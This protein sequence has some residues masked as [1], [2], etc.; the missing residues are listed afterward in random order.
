MASSTFTTYYTSP[1]GLLQIAGDATHIHS[2]LFWDEVTT[3]ASSTLPDHLQECLQQLDAY[4]K[5]ERQQ[6]DLPLSPVGTSFQQQVWQQLQ[7]IPFGKTAS[8][9]EVARVVSGEKAIRA[10]GGANGR[11][12]ISI[13]VPCHRVIGSDGSLTGYAGGLWRKEWLLQHEGILKPKQQL[14]LF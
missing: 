1:L 11:N 6:F 13:V 7:T 9:L 10:V 4:F 8:Y 3:E 14:A 12:P 5:G 2:I